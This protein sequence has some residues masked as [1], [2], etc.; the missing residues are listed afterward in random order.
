MR[1]V[2]TPT[3]S[4]GIPQCR[5]RK[6]PIA[7][8]LPNLVPPGPGDSGR[9]C[10]ESL[11]TRGNSAAGQDAGPCRSP[12]GHSG[13]TDSMSYHKDDVPKVG[14]GEQM[15]TILRS[16]PYRLFFYAGDGHEPP[17][18]HV[19][20]DDGAVKFWLDPVRLAKDVGFRPAELRRI[21]RVVE[22]HR[23][24]LMEAWHDYFQG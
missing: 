11:S 18:V 20:R 23:E 17:H 19:E 10:N 1:R 9:G 14:S 8:S 6:M 7:L 21:H 15:P 24:Q 5:G 13:L 16:G 22:E 3:A 12:L 2:G 4:A